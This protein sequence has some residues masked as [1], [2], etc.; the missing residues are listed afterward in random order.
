[1]GV[2]ASSHAPLSAR[3]VS[4]AAGRPA[5]RANASSGVQHA[6][7]DY[8]RQHLVGALIIPFLNWPAG[9]PADGPSGGRDAPTTSD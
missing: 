8:Q 3:K 4:D 1:M 9:Q 5:T 6:V 2:S 7:F